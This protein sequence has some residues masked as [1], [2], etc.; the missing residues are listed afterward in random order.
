MVGYSKKVKT[1]PETIQNLLKSA[2]ERLDPMEVI[3]FGSRARGDAGKHSD[4]D[5]ALKLTKEGKK[6]WTR[7]VVDV[8]DEAIT[9]FS[10]DLMDYDSLDDEY[11]KEI[12]AEGVLLYAKK[13]V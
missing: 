12:E 8:E 1:L 9:L 5:I 10:V 2:V 7:F 4:F 11:K 3:L 6:E 13:V